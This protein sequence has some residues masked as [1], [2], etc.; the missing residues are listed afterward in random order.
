MNKKKK[1]LLKE[2]EKTSY[3]DWVKLAEKSLKG[4]KVEDLIKMNLDGIEI[5]PYYSRD[6]FFEIEGQSDNL[7]GK[8][9]F[10]R[11]TSA[12]RKQPSICQIIP[13][14]LPEKYNEKLKKLLS[15]GQNS[16]HLKILPVTTDARKFRHGVL[17][18][19]VDDFEK[20][21]KDID[22]EEY[23]VYLE[24]E[25]S[26]YYAIDLFE[27]YL[28]SHN[29]D[30]TNLH[31]FYGLDSIAQ[32]IDTGQCQ[33]NVFDFID[34]IFRTTENLKHINTKRINPDGSIYARKGA[35]P[36]QEIAFVLSEA[37]SY[38]EHLLNSD[39]E[40]DDILRNIY[41]T[42]VVNGNFFEDIAKVRAMRAVW[43]FIVR[44]LGGT[45]ENAKADINLISTLTNKSPLDKE[46]NILRTTTET[47]SAILAGCNTFTVYPYT[48]PFEISDDFALRIGKN[49]QLVLLNE[50][51]LFSSIDP[52][53]GSWYIE[54]LTKEIIEK[55]KQLLNEID[56][57]GGI[58]KA[59]ENGFVQN[60]IQSDANEKLNN[61]ALRKEIYV[62]V[63]KYPNEKDKLQ[64]ESIKN[65]Q[66]ELSEYI[67]SN[68]T[69][70]KVPFYDTMPISV[71]ALDDFIPA[72]IFFELRKKAE[73]II[74][75]TGSEANVFVA[76]FGS[77][78]EYKSRVD[79][80]HDFLGTGGFKIEDNGKGYSTIDDAL[81]DWKKSEARIFAICSTDEIYSE[82]SK[83]L[84]DAF[85]S[86]KPQSIAILAGNPKEKIEEYKSAGIDYFIHIKA[87]IIELLDELLNKI[88]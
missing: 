9:P 78:K 81:K 40:I 60:L 11:A 30:D 47:A 88:K 79:F 37:I 61:I 15:A 14:F 7:P 69:E 56:K 68:P 20:I 41:F 84:V 67:S 76:A 44:E 35:S 13:E 12:T 87:N 8:F 55:T 33:Y 48:Y 3:S 65:M 71:Q 29:F 83:N 80:T 19:S 43:A 52:A 2:F 1:N 58:L 28:N 10:I 6:H 23:P 16:I 72:T 45:E 51:D 75:Q 46:T 25:H 74:K 22:L 66:N 73:N 49:I 5:E 31:L 39:Y 63:N 70:T 54:T 24:F 17:I 27:Q 36:V 21:F 26:S 77:L 64:N 18:Q 53:A 42:I 38:I 82:I 86:A 4:K 85:K 34:C 57:Q 50:T 32:L 62:G 59:L